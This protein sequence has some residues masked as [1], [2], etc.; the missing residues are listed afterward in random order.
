MYLPILVSKTN[1]SNC[2]IVTICKVM[3]MYEIT[4]SKS[5]ANQGKIYLNIIEILPE[6]P[7]RISKWYT[8][9]KPRK[10]NSIHKLYCHY[11][12]YRD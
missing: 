4:I 7:L 8:I 2:C 12:V 11:L 3:P 9:S 1:T 5:F 6:D 10:P